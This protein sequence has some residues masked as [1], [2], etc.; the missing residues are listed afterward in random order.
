M[1]TTAKRG[2]AKRRSP[3]AKAA[4]PAPERFTADGRKIVRLERLKAH[5]KYILKDGT[6]VVGA[7]T[8]AKLGDDQSN[9]IHWA[10]NLGNKNEDYRKVRDRA[11]DI[12][13]ITH[14]LIECFFHGWVADLSEFAPADIEKAGVAFNN[15]LS[16]WNEQGL[17]VLEPEV[18]LVSEQ[19]LFGGTIDAPSID[20]EGRIVDLDKF[21][22]VPASPLLADCDSLG[23]ANAPWCRRR[24]R[25][26]SSGICPPPPALPA[27]WVLPAVCALT[28]GCG[29]ARQ[30]QA[31][32][33]RARVQVCRKDRV[34]AVKGGGGDAA[35]N[36]NKAR[37]RPPRR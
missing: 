27:R 29:R 20:K 26:A 33:Y 22:C 14:F 30:E 36:S 15:F 18:Q 37:A 4:E 1:A 19:H 17:T 21:R 13:T 2:A 31:Q 8:I 11:A 23:G 34:L 10:W 25:L 6:Q 32:H 7:S 28:P 3:S 16:F 5:Q 12:G 24:R 9:L 35:N